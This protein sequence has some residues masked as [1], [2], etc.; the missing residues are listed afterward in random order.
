MSFMT[1]GTDIVFLLGL[2][3]SNHFI[4]AEISNR[5]GRQLLT[6]NFGIHFGHDLKIAILSHSTQLCIVNFLKIGIKCVHD[7]EMCATKC[8]MKMLHTKVVLKDIQESK[9]LERKAYSFRQGSECSLTATL[10]TTSLTRS[11]SFVAHRARSAFS[12]SLQLARKPRPLSTNGL[13]S[14]RIWKHAS[15]R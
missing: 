13:S 5:A 3:N 14:S 2:A 11:K 6:S 7:S 8:F 12:A 15:V 9:A 10:C 4:A 1:I